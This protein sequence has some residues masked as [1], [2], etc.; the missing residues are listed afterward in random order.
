MQVEALKLALLLLLKNKL[1]YP[2]SSQR[3][4]IATEVKG[5]WKAAEI[6]TVLKIFFLI[7]WLSGVII[8][9]LELNLS[10]FT[11]NSWSLPI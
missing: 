4:E 1:V 11:K 2:F 8:N 6:N 3:V 5:K 10:D 7:F 9:E